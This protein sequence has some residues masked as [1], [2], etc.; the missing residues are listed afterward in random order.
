MG[1][2]R[3]DVV[4]HLWQCDKDNHGWR[5]GPPVT[6]VLCQSLRSAGRV[7]TLRQSQFQRKKNTP[8]LCWL[9]A[10][11][12]DFGRF[13]TTIR[14]N[15]LFPSNGQRAVDSRLFPAALFGPD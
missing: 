3:I 11:T 8:L 2:P 4:F 6:V 10:F 15:R 12:Q 14:P 5:E 13:K 9:R 7:F 1:S